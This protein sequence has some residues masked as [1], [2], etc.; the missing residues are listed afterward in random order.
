LGKRWVETNWNV[1]KHNMPLKASES[2]LLTMQLIDELVAKY[3]I[4]KTR[5]YITGLSMGGFGT[6]DLICRYPGVFAAAVPICGGGDIKK[7]ALLKNTPI[8]VFHGS[9]DNVVKVVLSRNM[10]NAIK[11]SGGKPKYTE[12]KGIGHN[13]WEKAYQE[14]GLLEWL[15]RQSLK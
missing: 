7:A 8:W 15:F 1:S 3:P 4:D 14:K 5:I 12:Y 9:I 2:I 10:V 6:W 13:S 11:A